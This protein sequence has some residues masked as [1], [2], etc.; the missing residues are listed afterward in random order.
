[1]QPLLFGGLHW[2]GCWLS[3][4]SSSGVE[5]RAKPIFSSAGFFDCFCCVSVA[6]Q[7][8][9]LSGL[10]H[11][12]VPRREDGVGYADVCRNFQ[13]WAGVASTDTYDVQLLH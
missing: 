13:L 9:V 1:M 5:A 6:C 4:S 3:F 7:S 11:C 12:L 2:L 8:V 10:S